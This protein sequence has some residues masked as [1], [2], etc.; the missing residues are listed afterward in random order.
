MNGM[1]RLWKTAKRIKIVLIIICIGLTALSCGKDGSI[2]GAV[3]WDYTLYYASIGGFPSSGTYGVYYKINPGTYNVY[4]TIYDGIYYYP[5]Y[6]VG[7]GGNSSYYWIASYSVTAEEGSFPLIDGED[8]QFAL[9][10]AI[11]GMYKAGAVNYILS[12]PRDLQSM[13]PK[14]GTQSWTENGLRITVTN[15]IAQLTPEE[16]SRIEQTHMEKK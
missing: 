10:L 12:P 13:T 16:F 9:W 7:A 15:R 2:F 3:V 4:Y 8:K 11:D 14:L 1:K 5:G 6:W